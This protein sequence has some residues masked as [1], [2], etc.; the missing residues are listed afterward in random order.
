MERVEEPALRVW[1]WWGVGGVAALFTQAILQ[2][3]R[4]GILTLRAG[5]DP[6]EW[7]VLIALAAALLW[8]EG[9]LA[10]DRKWVPR[11]VARAAR[12][13]ARSRP[14]DR[15]LAPLYAMS[16]IGAS[17]GTLARAWLGVALVV[18]AV[19]AVRALAEPWRGLVD[20]AVALALLWGLIAIVRQGIA[21]PL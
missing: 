16:L 14:I 17:R 3:G 2:L 7:L 15:A 18:A 20:L 19:L 11:M 8:G 9:V 10:L 12:L 1:Y 6:L 4:R 13:D 5:L 21:D